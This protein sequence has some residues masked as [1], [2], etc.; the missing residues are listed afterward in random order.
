MTYEKGTFTVV[1]NSKII[2]TLPIEARSIYLAICIFADSDGTCF[3]SRKAL[4]R[5]SGI[6][7]ER[8]LDKYVEVLVLSGIISKQLRKKSGSKENTSNMYTINMLPTPDTE[9]VPAHHTSTVPAPDNTETISTLTIPNLT[10][11]VENLTEEK[12]GGELPVSFGKTY[13]L[14]LLSMYNRLFRHKYGFSPSIDVGR[15]GKLAKQLVVSHTELQIAC[16]M[17]VF[18]EWRGMSGSDEIAQKKLLDATFNPHWFGSTINQY[19]AYLRNVVQIDF[20]NNES[21][22]KFIRENLPK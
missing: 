14:R 1:P 7:S 15:F 17:L 13:M 3:P 2:Q 6:K 10:K 16:L 22:T 18:F 4:A 9:T 8:T 5:A 12:K 21:L 19:E 11:V 20:D